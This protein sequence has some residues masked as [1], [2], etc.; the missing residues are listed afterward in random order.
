MKE[1]Y[2]KLHDERRGYSNR[3]G[4]V[5]RRWG[6]EQNQM[7]LKTEIM[8]DYSDKCHYLYLDAKGK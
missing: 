7:K 2:R 5:S 4:S 3:I 8:Q 6:R 1:I